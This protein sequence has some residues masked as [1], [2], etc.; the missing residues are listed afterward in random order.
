MDSYIFKNNSKTIPVAIN[1]IKSQLVQYYDVIV[2]V[3]EA[4]YIFDEIC[5]SIFLSA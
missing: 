2:T 3:Y 1:H 5:I 4:R